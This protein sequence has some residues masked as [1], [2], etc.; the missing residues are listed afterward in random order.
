MRHAAL[1]WSILVSEFGEQIIAT[2]S[3][4]PYPVLTKPKFH[5]HLSEIE[6]GE[7]ERERG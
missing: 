2:K 6:G 3:G 5:H 7:R 4:E 1:T